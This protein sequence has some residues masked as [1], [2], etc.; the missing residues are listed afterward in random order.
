MT[1]GSGWNIMCFNGGVRFIA[2]CETDNGDFAFPMDLDADCW[3]HLALVYDG[4]TAIGFIDG[5]QV[6]S[7]NGSGNIMLSSWDV[8]IGARLEPDMVKSPIS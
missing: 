2:I 8:I 3:Y 1:K 6:G 4:S 7:D 5:V